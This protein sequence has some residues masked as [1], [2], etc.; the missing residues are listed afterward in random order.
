MEDTST[1]TTTAALASTHTDPYGWRRKRYGL[2]VL[3]AVGSGGYTTFG[4]N[5]NRSRVHVVDFKR[6][7]GGGETNNFFLSLPPR[8]PPLPFFHP[9][10]CP[11]FL[12]M[13]FSLYVNEER[14]RSD[15]LGHSILPFGEEE[16][17]CLAHYVRA[18]A[19]AALA[20]YI[21]RHINISIMLDVYIL[22]SA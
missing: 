15:A 3:S 7:W 1:T 12:P 5:K 6:R 16:R 10:S 19:H 20:S 9:S 14:E 18:P 2:P 21:R 13:Q 17:R 11:A 22:S 8:H 4:H